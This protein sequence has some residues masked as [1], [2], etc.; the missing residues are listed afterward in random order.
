MVAVAASAPAP[1]PAVPLP[2]SAPLLCL[3]PSYP[4]MKIYPGGHTHHLCTRRGL[5]VAYRR[6]L[7]VVATASLRRLTGVTTRDANPDNDGQRWS[8]FKFCTQTLQPGATTQLTTGFGAISRGASVC[9]PT[10]TDVLGTITFDQTKSTIPLVLEDVFA[11]T[12]TKVEL[13]GDAEKGQSFDPQVR[14]G[15][16]LNVTAADQP[17]LAANRNV[18]LRPKEQNVN[19]RARTTRFKDKIQMC[20]VPPFFS[21]CLSPTVD[22]TIEQRND[23]A[24][25]EVV[26]FYNAYQETVVRGLEAGTAAKCQWQASSQLRR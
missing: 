22:R 4:S 1:T 21:F 18:D 11:A 17:S 6:Q 20:V 24:W 12:P 2:A 15:D 13:D 7:A 3:V 16:D 19:D 14:R 25:A 26:H 10:V 9:I 8:S 23:D 5:H